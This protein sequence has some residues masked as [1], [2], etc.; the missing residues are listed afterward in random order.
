MLKSE[1]FIKAK[2]GRKETLGKILSCYFWFSFKKCL[3]SF[4]THPEVVK[5]VQKSLDALSSVPP[6]YCFLGK[7]HFV[8]F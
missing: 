3:T 1:F 7:V 2:G 4:Q 6:L 5:T 8:G